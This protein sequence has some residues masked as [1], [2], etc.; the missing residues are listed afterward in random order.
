MSAVE[1]RVTFN[2]KEV[3]FY[4]SLVDGSTKIV[5]HTKPECT[6]LFECEDPSCTV[7][8]RLDAKYDLEFAFMMG[9][10]FAASMLGDVCR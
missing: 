1:K 10:E 2:G 7:S 4:A 6:D 3:A 8:V 5:H 9:V